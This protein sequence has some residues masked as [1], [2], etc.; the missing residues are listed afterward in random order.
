MLGVILWRKRTFKGRFLL[1]REFKD[2]LEIM[3]YDSSS[4][5]SSN[6]DEDMDLLFLPPS[7]PTQVDRL[8]W[9]R[10]GNFS[11]QTVYHVEKNS[12]GEAPGSAQSARAKISSIYD[13]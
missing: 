9:A 1:R 7:L 2:L 12:G 8:A 11:R 4:S 10:G 6:E 3:A 13:Y 5:E